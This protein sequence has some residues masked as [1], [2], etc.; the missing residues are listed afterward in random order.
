[1]RTLEAYADPGTMPASE[2]MRIAQLL[3]LTVAKGFDDVALAQRVAE[4]LPPSAVTALVN[5]FGRLEIV[6]PVV[7]EA[8]LRR[9]RKGRKPLPKEHSERIYELG[10]VID[11]V[12]RAF[13]GDRARIESFLKRPHT[14]LGGESPF[15][16]ARSS[17]AGADAVLNLLRRAEAGVAL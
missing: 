17:S 10:R 14:L 16:M 7:S 13:H 2:P 3:S 5:M 8:T 6:G 4:G 15:D 9:A 11:A 1:M 12:G